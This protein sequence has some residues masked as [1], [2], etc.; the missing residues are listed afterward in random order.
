MAPFSSIQKGCMTLNFTAKS[1]YLHVKLKDKC[2]H[3]L[4]LPLS[5]FNWH[6]SNLLCNPQIG[7]FLTQTL[8]IG[9]GNSNVE[10]NRITNI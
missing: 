9:A 7:Y 10:T 5:I 8:H 6:I 2:L 1:F 3:R 4:F